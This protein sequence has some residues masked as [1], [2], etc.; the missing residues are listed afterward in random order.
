MEDNVP[1]GTES[2]AP[3]TSPSPSPSPATQST[4]SDASPKLDADTGREAKSSLLDAVLKVVPATNE[5]D[6]LAEGE[7]ADGE[8][9]PEPH[10]PDDPDQAEAPEADGED[11][12]D[13]EEHEA[14]PAI[15]KKINKLLKQRREL[16]G[17]VEGLRGEVQ[18]LH[19][20]AQVGG[21]LEQFARTAQLS[22]DDVAN[23]LKTMAALRSG[24]Y[25][26]FYQMVAPFVRTAQE[27]LGIVLP[28]DLG[29]RV[30]QG[31]L[32]EAAAKEFARQRFDHQRAQIT[33]QEHE[34]ANQQLALQN[35]QGNVQRAVTSFEQRLAASDPDYKAKAPSVRR[36]AQ[37]LLLERGGRIGT[38]E[39]AL[40]ITKAAY[41]EVN[42]HTRS[43]LPRPR[44]TGSLPNGSTQTPSA[45]SAPK[46]LMEA[47]L[48][49]LENS[50][51]A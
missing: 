5:K 1:A 3:D 40:D 15:R 4:P 49:G 42:R 24:D 38:V 30:R 50:R 14:P 23:G 46:S 27:Y 11:V 34:A 8:A 26:T 12:P 7:E 51:R 6:V 18:R 31:H 41:D 32:T 36:V 19:G 21:E 25:A 10:T 29:E 9:A 43:I 22:G 39:E 20:A 44:A 48:Q 33:V 17:E 45:R 47:A 13:A 35:V 16:R 28:R 37:A 2:T